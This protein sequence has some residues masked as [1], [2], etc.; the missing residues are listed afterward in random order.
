MAQPVSR[1]EFFHD[2]TMFYVEI[3][4]KH[5]HPR[6]DASSLHGL[7]TY[8]P[9][10]GLAPTKKD[11][12]AKGLPPP[13]KD[14]PPHFYT[15]QMIHYGLKPLKTRDPAKKK[16]LAAFGG[17]ATL[18]VPAHILQLEQQ[19]ATEFAVNNKGAAKQPKTKKAKEAKQASPAVALAKQDPS[20]D[21]P[22]PAARDPKASKK[23][24]PPVD[25]QA[26][27]SSLEGLKHQDLV[28]II[29]HVA[30]DPA[31]HSS[32][33]EQVRELQAAAPL[34]RFLPPPVPPPAPTAMR[35]DLIIP[36]KPAR[37]KQTARKSTYSRPPRR[38]IIKPTSGA[39]EPVGT[40]ELS[41]P[42]I[43]EEWPQ[44][45][46]DTPCLDVC[47]SST[48]AHLW[49]SFDFGVVS[50]VFRSFGAAPTAANLKTDFRWRGREEGEGE[51]Q[52]GQGLKGY[53]KFLDGGSRVQGCIEG[54]FLGKAEFTGELVDDDVGVDPVEEWKRRWRGINMSAYEVSSARR[55]GMWGGE[56]KPDKP[57]ASD[58]SGGEEGVE[59]D[60]DGAGDMRMAGDDFESEE[61]K[62]RG[63]IKPRTKQTARR[64]GAPAFGVS[65]ADSATRSTQE[66]A[67]SQPSGSGPAPKYKTK[68]TAR[69]GGPSRPQTIRVPANAPFRPT[70]SYTI[71]AEDFADLCSSYFDEEDMTLDVRPSSTGA[72][73]WGK[74]D[75]GALSGVFRSTGSAPTSGGKK[76]PIIWRGSD[77]EAVDGRTWY[78]EGQTGFIKFL[79]GGKVKGCLEGYMAKGDFTGQLLEGEV[80]LSEVAEWKSEWRSLNEA[81]SIAS[82]KSR[83][84][85]WTA[86]PRADR[87]AASD[88]SGGEGDSMDV[89]EDEYY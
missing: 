76:V 28:K 26:L 70:G 65:R 11:N 12:I 85:T 73:L 42:E 8:T 46:G 17:G 1:D 57:D 7:L 15:A 33:T 36:P 67:P 88:T 62:P 34:I 32:I 71:V 38:P 39:F 4:G 3:D 61:E 25:V 20:N 63:T 86:E 10:S 44:Y 83:W 68:Q 74:F 50:G 72:H 24:P 49:G 55:W 58:T 31:V 82:S 75:F 6:C 59:D 78:D 84:G 69:R 40:Y 16:L 77:S 45:G 37:T 79:S 19:L 5:R 23:A 87:A 18:V 35:M 14:P 80:D 81:D 56:A 41:V 9:P 13:H 29:L 53:I 21:A 54:S 52:L 64:G 2:G 48:G 60:S 89:D 22:P 30:Q 51:M 66:T 27:R 47:P 43:E